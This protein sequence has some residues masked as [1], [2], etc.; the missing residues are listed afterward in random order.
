MASLRIAGATV[1][2]NTV[3]I[4]I[5]LALLSG[6]MGLFWQQIM[7]LPTSTPQTFA[8]HFYQRALGQLDGRSCP[9]YPVCSRYARQAFEHHHW[10]IASWLTLDRLIHEADDVKTGHSVMFEGESRLYDPLKRN[11]FWL[12]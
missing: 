2:K 3:H 12:N 8:I 11:D 10:L 7:H 1:V 5:A 6:A 4:Y 9:S